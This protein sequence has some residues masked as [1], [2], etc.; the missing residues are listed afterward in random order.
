MKPGFDDSVGRELR[1]L[2]SVDPAPGFTAR[3]RERI[4]S[5]P[6]PRRW[7]FPRMFAVAGAIAAA[8]VAA[9]FVFQPR[10]HEISNVQQETARPEAPL[11]IAAPSPRK[12]PLVDHLI[13]KVAR[14]EPQLMIAANEA[15]ALRRL[16]SGEVKELPSRFEPQVREFQIPDAIVEPLSPPEL[17]AIDPIELPDAAVPDLRR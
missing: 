12:A 15:I 8:L 10:G 5:E 16:L 4:D 11:P 17:I 2:V 7:S 13:L 9:V 3:I 14:P 1:E 6:Q